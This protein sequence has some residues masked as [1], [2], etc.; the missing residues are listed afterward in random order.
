[1]K[2]INC[3]SEWN[4]TGQAAVSIVNC[5]F[6][7]ESPVVKK[8][9]KKSFETSKEALEAIYKQFGADILLGKLNA[10]IADFAPSLSTA[11]KRLVNSVYEFGASKVLKEN[12]NGSQEDKERAVKIAVRNM[13]DAFVKDDIAENIIYEFTNALE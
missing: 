11:N 9:E 13:T 2:C 8:A 5:P 3:G 4:A 10:Y 6:C 7:G 12:L 1:M